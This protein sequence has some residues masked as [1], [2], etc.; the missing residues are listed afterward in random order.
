VIP[1]QGDGH[2]PNGKQKF[3]CQTGGRGSGENPTPN[4]YPEARREEIRHTYQEPGNPAPG[5]RRKNSQ[6]LAKSVFLLTT[7]HATD[8]L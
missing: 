4:A 1:G 7:P 5:A 6:T 8:T 2:A 3:R